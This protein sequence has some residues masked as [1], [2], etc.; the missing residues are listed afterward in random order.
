MDISNGL[1]FCDASYFVFYRYYAVM[2]WYKKSLERDVDVSGV[3]S[4]QEFMEKFDSTFE[5]LIVDIGKRH[6]VPL[7]NVVFARD[8]SRENIWRT[9]L[10]PKY[11]ATRDAKAGSFN[12]DIFKHTYDVLFPR[13]KAVHGFKEMSHPKLE[14]DDLIAI[15]VKAL[16]GMEGVGKITVITNDNDYVQLYKY[17]IDIINLQKKALKERV[18]DVMTYLDYKVIIGD[19]S[20][21]IPAVAKKVGDKTA[22][23]M[24]AD[25]ALFD[26]MMQ[27]DGVKDQYELNITLIDFDRIPVQYQK[28]VLNALKE[29]LKN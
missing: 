6:R 27:G 8:C 15:S 14:A 2:G 22:Q 10:Y 13:L 1:V 19:K 5:R 17:G 29:M 4:D 28:E 18:D 21:N 3:L 26:R 12:G 25:K 16:H 7:T 24:V 23:K 9:A 20:D 11:K